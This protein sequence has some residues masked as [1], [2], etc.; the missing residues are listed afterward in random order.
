M[1]NWG[2]RKL[3]KNVSS[4]PQHIHNRRKGL[5]VDKVTQLCRTFVA[6]KVHL[7]LGTRAKQFQKA[8]TTILKEWRKNKKWKKK[9][10]WRDSN[11]GATCA[12]HVSWPQKL[13]STDIVFSSLSGSLKHMMLILAGN[14]VLLKFTVS[15]R[16]FTVRFDFHSAGSEKRM[17][18]CSF[19]GFTPRPA[20]SINSFVWVFNLPSFI[21]P[22]T[23]TKQCFWKRISTIERL[24]QPRSNGPLK[25]PCK[26]ESQNRTQVPEFDRFW[27]PFSSPKFYRPG[28]YRGKKSRISRSG[29]HFSQKIHISAEKACKHKFSTI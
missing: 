3:Q 2:D 27:K 9:C 15:P 8:L 7:L 12:A 5:L 11:P 21:I 20:E 18:G 17:T 14:P 26:I 25:H 10:F 19:C 29:L 22:G 6:D 13:T 24:Y 28:N 1:K 16:V 23:C 4:T